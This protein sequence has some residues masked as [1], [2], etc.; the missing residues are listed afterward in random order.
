[1][2]ERKGEKYFAPQKE[3]IYYGSA[4]LPTNEKERKSKIK[5][6]FCVTLEETNLRGFFAN[7]EEKEEFDYRL[8]T[9]SSLLKR[10]N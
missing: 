4:N 9:I 6:G 7:E 2:K 5:N 1:M 10:L 8:P 3:V